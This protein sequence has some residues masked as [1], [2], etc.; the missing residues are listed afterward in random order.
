MPSADI[1]TCASL[2]CPK[3]WRCAEHYSNFTYAEIRDARDVSHHDPYRPE[4]GGCEHFRETKGGHQ[5]TDILTIIA[6]LRELEK[7]ATPEP[8]EV[9]MFVVKRTGAD[10]DVCMEP[11]DGYKNPPE[12]WKDNL[13]YIAASRNAMPRLLDYIA[14]LEAEAGVRRELYRT[15]CE[16]LLT[17]AEAEVEHLLAVND[18]L[19]ARVKKL[20][21]LL[22]ES[23]SFLGSDWRE[24]RDA[25]LAECEEVRRGKRKTRCARL[26]PSWGICTCNADKPTPPTPTEDEVREAREYL[27]RR[28]STTE[29]VM[30]PRRHFRHVQT[31]LTALTAR[32]ERIGDLEMMLDRASGDAE[33]RYSLALGTVKNELAVSREREKRLRD[34]L[35]ESQ[36]SIGGD[37]RQ[38]RDAALKEASK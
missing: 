38:R 1:T 35:I 19:Q 5:M 8:W 6:E 3:R 16:Q 17:S 9:D 23:Q 28:I 4:I 37:W 33:E 31:I 13:A 22:V 12:D 24:R 20:R 34:L 15:Q 7:K 18:A 27:S 29:K 2:H 14:K 11:E 32:D 26:D 25:A 30:L 36:E 21:A 10:Y